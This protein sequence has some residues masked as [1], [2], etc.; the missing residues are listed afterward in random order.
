MIDT[1]GRELKTPKGRVL[2]EALIF[3]VFQR[4]K[5]SNSGF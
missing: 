5:H 4:S 3:W 1:E 2:A